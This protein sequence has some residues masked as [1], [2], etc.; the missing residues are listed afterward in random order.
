VLF[1]LA[2][3]NRAV[4]AMDEAT[5]W[6]EAFAKALPRSPNAHWLFFQQR[7]TEGHT[8][9]AELYTT[10]CGAQT[11]VLARKMLE[12]SERALASTRSSERAGEGDV[13]R[14]EA[15]IM[16]AL[17]L[18]RSLPADDQNPELIARAVDA[19]AASTGA[20]PATA[21]RAAVE[22]EGVLLTAR[23]FEEES[24]A[25]ASARNSLQNVRSCVPEER[26]SCKACG[27][28]KPKVAY[29]DNQWRKGQ[30]RCRPCQS[31][32]I[33]T[34]VTQRTEGQAAEEEASA[35]RALY[36]QHL[37]AEENR[38][39]EELARRNKNEHN[40]ADCVICFDETTPDERI[41]LHGTMHWLCA[42]CLK[43]MLAV[44]K[45][46]VRCPMCKE[47]LDEDKLRTMLL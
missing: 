40:D 35:L 37:Q 43:E 28:H 34:T 22:I 39:Q 11:R 4:H 14:A 7:N 17:H 2:Y 33:T 8:E 46:P 3:T 12:V 15:S 30:R 36:E 29:S 9:A 19:L 41:V 42:G 21:A 10:V 23:G 47:E 45:R 26:R 38:V 24:A 44:K 13:L 5:R 16:K 20:R 31:A 27:E 32:Q 18:L 6:S 25:G 1:E